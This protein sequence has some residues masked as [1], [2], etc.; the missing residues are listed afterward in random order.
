MT[1]YVRIKDPGTGAEITYDTA[2]VEALGLQDHVIDKDPLGP[3]GLPAPTK[4]SLPLGEPVPGTPQDRRREQRRQ[5]RQ[6]D[7]ASTT[8]T[9]GAPDPGQDAGQTSADPEKEN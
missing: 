5:E 4:P 1:D 2:K 7:S 9:P 3:D 8:Q 6:Q